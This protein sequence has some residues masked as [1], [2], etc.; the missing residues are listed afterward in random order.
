MAGGKQ[1]AVKSLQGTRPTKPPPLPPR[2]P[3]HHP[4]LPPNT[5]HHGLQ[6]LVAGEAHAQ[7]GVDKV[8]VAVHQLLQARR[9]LVGQ[10]AERL[11]EQGAECGPEEV[12]RLLRQSAPAAAGG[13]RSGRAGCRGPEGGCETQAGARE[14]WGIGRWGEATAAECV[15]SAA[16]LPGSR[17]K[18]SGRLH[19]SAHFPY[20]SLT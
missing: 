10:A 17:K 11:R 15:R 2:C 6:A 12:T 9:E 1:R 5:A 16:A 19:P 7:G 3:A 8:D 4:H 13:E 14:E 20:P 18:I